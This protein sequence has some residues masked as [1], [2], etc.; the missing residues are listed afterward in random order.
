MLRLTLSPD[1]LQ[2]FRLFYYL[3]KNERIRAQMGF[4]VD[5]PYG[6]AHGIWRYYDN[7]PNAW[8]QRLA[9]FFIAYVNDD[10]LSIAD[11][12]P[13]ADVSQMRYRGQIA[14]RNT[15][16]ARDVYLA[17]V[18][19]VLYLD[20]YRKVPWR[21]VDWSD[22]ELS[23]LLSSKVCFRAERLGASRE[24]YYTVHLSSRS[25]ETEN[26]LHDPRIVY[27]FMNSTPEQGECL[28]GAT[29]GETGQNLTGWFH[30]YLWHN[31]AQLD[32]DNFYLEYPCV[33][34]RLQRHPV[35][36]LGEVYL[37]PSGC[38]SASSLFADLM[39]SVNI[40]VRKVHNV[41][42]SASGVE[43]H[44]CGLVFDWQGGSGRGRYLLHTDDIY[45]SF[46][47]KDPAPEP[48]N[49]ARGV[50]LWDQVWLEPTRFGKTFQFAAE[51]NIFACATWGQ[52]ENYRWQ[53][54]WLVSSARAISEARSLGG[55][56]RVIEAL[57]TQRGL[58]ESEAEACWQAIEASVLSYGDGNMESGY[59][60]LLDGPASRH[61]QW[62][63]RTGKCT[64][65][66][67]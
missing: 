61:E 28:I 58:T 13:L 60:L 16:L 52:M 8:Q 9:T 49:T 26:I 59:Q 54:D 41:L 37:T 56:D 46:F 1:W 21:L 33:E 63:E 47:F 22:H 42:L 20:V 31:P 4:E 40:P 39:R 67:P 44:H 17:Q 11:A 65:M 15:D 43:G 53:N 7:W 55:R 5:R 36:P 6:S 3:H 64:Q 25:D 45:W 62:C 2:R 32:K 57:Q 24:L 66:A 10:S 18:A 27:R 38:G 50:A 12:L 51:E 30:D 23:Y 29:P 48:R 19:H 35:D 14:Y 34:H